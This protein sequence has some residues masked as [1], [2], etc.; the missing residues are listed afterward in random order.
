MTD[1]PYRDST[2]GECAT[3]RAKVRRAED[4][5]KWFQSE[6]KLEVE[7]RAN[8]LEGRA[9]WSLFGMCLFVLGGSILIE[10]QHLPVS[11]ATFFV[12]AILGI[13]SWRAELR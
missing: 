1:S 4:G 10:M 9:R 8:G 2:C 13:I 7:R 11:I 12:A 6:L 5:E 3:L